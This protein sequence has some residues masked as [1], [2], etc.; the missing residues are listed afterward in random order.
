V[1]EKHVF[2]KL[3]EG[4]EGGVKLFESGS[5]QFIYMSIAIVICVLFHTQLYKSLRSIFIYF[6]PRGYQYPKRVY[7]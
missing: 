6:P 2:S 1:E 3:Q 5:Y 4:A 7:E